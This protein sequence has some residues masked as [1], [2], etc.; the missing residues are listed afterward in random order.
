MKND[1]SVAKTSFIIV[2]LSVLLVSCGGGG[3]STPN[4]NAQPSDP[5]GNQTPTASNWNAMKWD[6]DVWN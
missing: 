5:T 4:Q 6:S 2:A 1:T 3:S